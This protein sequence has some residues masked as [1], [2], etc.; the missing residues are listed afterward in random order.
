MP[1]Y[2]AY[3]FFKKQPPSVVTPDGNSGLGQGG[4]VKP[5][6]NNPIPPSP[7]PANVVPPQGGDIKPPAPTIEPDIRNLN[8]AVLDINNRP[9][10]NLVAGQTIKLTSEYTV[11]AAPDVKTVDVEENRYFIL[12]DGTRTQ[13]M[14][15]TIQRETGTVVSKATM[16][17]PSGIL[18]GTYTYVVTVKVGKKINKATQTV[19]VAAVEKK[20]DQDKTITQREIDDYLAEGKQFFDR[21]K[22]ELCIEKMKEVIKRDNGNREAKQYIRMASEKINNIKRQFSNPTFGGS[23]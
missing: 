12:P 7:A 21:G 17:L 2:R 11:M 10:E 23:E 16:T 1:F 3:F 4:T 19:I 6:I 14:I 20:P 22:Y 8:A 18:S 5:P 15:R 13:D 9:I